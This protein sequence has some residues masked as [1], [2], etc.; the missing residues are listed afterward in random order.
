LKSLLV[1]RA[2]FLQVDTSKE[3]KDKLIVVH[4]K[5]AQVDKCKERK[6]KLKMSDRKRNVVLMQNSIV[7]AYFARQPRLS[8]IPRITSS[9]EQ[10]Q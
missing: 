1:K 4:T 2:N 3:R 5:F 6:E 10:I 8:H 7:L 9:S